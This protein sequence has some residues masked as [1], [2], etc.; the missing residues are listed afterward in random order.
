MESEDLKK[1]FEASVVT[2]RANS[3]GTGFFIA[4]GLILTCAHVVAGSHSLGTHPIEIRWQDKTY[5]GQ[6]DKLLINTADLD[7]AVIRC[8]DIDA[9][10]PCVYLDATVNVG[11]DL[12]CYSQLRISRR[13][14]A[15]TTRPTPST[16]KCA[17]YAAGGRLLTITNG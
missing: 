7:L 11:H 10:H 15:P 16:P 12:Y 8:L 14:E 17:G 5:V 9:D 13:Y 2:V 3:Y 6:I 1:L 4:P